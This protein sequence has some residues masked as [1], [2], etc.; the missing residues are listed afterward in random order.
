[1]K[2][3]GS[4]VRPG[5]FMSFSV[6]DFS[7]PRRDSQDDVLVFI[8]EVPYRKDPEKPVSVREAVYQPQEPVPD[9]PE[10]FRRQKDFMDHEYPEWVDDTPPWRNPDARGDTY[11]YVW[12]QHQARIRG[13]H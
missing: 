7:P 3:P 6:A 1:M 4:Q 12:Q 9:K 13:H 10:S 2:G 8:E 11:L 5:F